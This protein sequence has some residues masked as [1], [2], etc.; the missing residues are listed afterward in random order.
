L[1][2]DVKDDVGGSQALGIK[3]ILVK[4]GKYLEGD[5][6]KHENIRPYFVANSFCEAVFQIL[7]LSDGEKQKCHEK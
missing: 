1:F 6:K 4:T 7:T 3:G 2:V 5:E